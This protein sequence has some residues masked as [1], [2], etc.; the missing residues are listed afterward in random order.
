MRYKRLFDNYTIDIDNFMDEFI[1]SEEEPYRLI[2]LDNSKRYVY[3]DQV[4]VDIIHYVNSLGNKPIMIIDNDIA[5]S[6]VVI[7]DAN[8]TLCNYLADQIG[9][10]IKPTS[11]WTGSELYL[12]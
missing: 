1:D 5:N 9:K 8:W 2:L 4:N 10:N 3:P 7:Y 12:L 6:I 11:H